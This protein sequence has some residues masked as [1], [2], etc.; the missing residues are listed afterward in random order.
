MKQEINEG[1][2]NGKED[3]THFNLE[4]HIKSHSNVK[5]IY[6]INLNKRG[7]ASIVDNSST[8]LKSAMLLKMQYI[9]CCNHKF[10]IDMQI[11]IKKSIGQYYS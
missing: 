5:D 4:T 7:R 11:M 3:E 1:I 6:D 9:R 10:N 2:G 8:N